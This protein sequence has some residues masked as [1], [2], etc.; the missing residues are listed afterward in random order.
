MIF[1]RYTSYAYILSFVSIFCLTINPPLFWANISFEI[2]SSNSL[3]YCSIVCKTFLNGSIYYNI[4]LITEDLK[5]QMSPL[6][7]PLHSLQLQLHSI[8]GQT[9]QLSLSL[10]LTRHP[11]LQSFHPTI[12]SIS[13]HFTHSLSH[14]FTLSLSI[15]TSTLTNYQSIFKHLNTQ[16]THLHTY[17]KIIL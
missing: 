15:H 2:I 9:N 11:S 3:I 13:F 8:T 10:L 5:Q 6:H 12:N 14:S 17:Q 16:Q 7:P 4:V 1:G